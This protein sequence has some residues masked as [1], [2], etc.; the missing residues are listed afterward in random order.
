MPLSTSGDQSP[1]TRKVVEARLQALSSKWAEL[2]PAFLK[3]RQA[4]YAAKDQDNTYTVY[5]ASNDLD[6]A[7]NEVEEYSSCMMEAKRTFKVII[8]TM[9]LI[10]RMKT[11]RW[12]KVSWKNGN[13]T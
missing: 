11:Q 2:A 5:I 13:R 12:Y 10:L 3:A 4:L 9:T 6:K 1:D 8:M 7:A